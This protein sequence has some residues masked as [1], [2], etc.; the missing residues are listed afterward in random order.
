VT[1]AS[2]DLER[3]ATLAEVLRARFQQEGVGIEAYGRYLQAHAGQTPGELLAEL[4]ALAHG[5]HPAYFRTLFL[6]ES[7]P[8]VWPA[9]FGIV[10]AWA[11]TGEQWSAAQNQEADDQLRR[12]IQTRGL[13]HQ[14]LTGIS[15]DGK[16]AEPGW[17]LTAARADVVALGRDF[18]QDAVYWVESDQLQVLSCREDRSAMVGRFAERVRAAAE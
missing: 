6:A 1:I 17:A 3:I 5:F 14:R 11:T 4:L 10:T 13:P 15:P 7:I 18:L 12:V 8:P 9:A 16:H 2:H